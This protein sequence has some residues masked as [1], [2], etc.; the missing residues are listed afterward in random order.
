MTSGHII[1]YQQGA[2]PL[3]RPLTQSAPEAVNGQQ[4]VKTTKYKPLRK[5]CRTAALGCLLQAR[6]PASPYIVVNEALTLEEDN[7]V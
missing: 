6:A 3:I 4:P 7:L 1:C 5:S 2:L